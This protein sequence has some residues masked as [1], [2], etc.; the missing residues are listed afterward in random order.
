M[1]RYRV[2]M[3][4]GIKSGDFPNDPAALSREN[5][6]PAELHNDLM[7]EAVITSP[8]NP[9]LGHGPTELRNP[10]RH[11]I[12]AAWLDL[13]AAPTKQIAEQTNKTMAVAGLDHRVSPGIIFTWRC[14]KK[15]QSL[16]RE[17][18]QR[19]IAALVSAFEAEA[20]KEDFN[21]GTFGQGLALFK[22]EVT[23]PTLKGI[24]EI[25]RT[26]SNPVIRVISKVVRVEWYRNLGKREAREAKQMARELFPYGE[27]VQALRP[28]FDDAADKGD[29]V[30]MRKVYGLLERIATPLALAEDARTE[31]KALRRESKESQEFKGDRSRGRR[32]K[33]RTR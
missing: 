10:P 9:R 2:T 6:I 24:T 18:R 1:A 28:L 16:V 3:F 11:K 30:R 27:Q 15:F 7:V 14:D 12:A 25:E 33:V 31:A 21:A 13:V 19:L 8:E 4:S 17:A 5:C 22:N 23:L 20:T 32:A 29:S 26:T